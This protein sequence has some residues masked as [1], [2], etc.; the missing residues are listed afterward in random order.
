MSKNYLDAQVSL[1]RVFSIVMWQGHYYCSILNE[2]VVPSCL[3]SCPSKLS[4][5]YQQA[6]PIKPLFVLGG[7]PYTVSSSGN[8][9]AHLIRRLKLIP[10][11]ESWAQATQ[12][13]VQGVSPLCHH[14]HLEGIRTVW[15]PTWELTVLELKT[16]LWLWLLSPSKVLLFNPYYHLASALTKCI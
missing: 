12:S 9:F 5:F 3:L 2:E 14:C 8:H 10:D 6:P 15:S 16:P 13:T 4:L 7:P 11:C 1:W